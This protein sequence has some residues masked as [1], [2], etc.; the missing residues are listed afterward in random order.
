MKTVLW[1]GCFGIW[2]YSTCPP[3][4]KL[5]RQMVIGRRIE[6]IHFWHEKGSIASTICKF[7]LPV[8]NE[9]LFIHHITPPKLHSECSWSKQC[10]FAALLDW[11]IPRFKRTS[12]TRTHASFYETM[13]TWSFLGHWERPFILFSFTVLSAEAA[14][15]CKVHC[16]FDLLPKTNPWLHMNWTVADFRLGHKSHWVNCLIIQLVLVCVRLCPE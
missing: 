10:D 1:L 13:F 12:C 2:T 4:D 8:I 16:L 14:I 5:S 6:T 7:D 11:L 3:L 15:N 9:K